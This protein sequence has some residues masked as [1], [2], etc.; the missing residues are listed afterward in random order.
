MALVEEKR[1]H[2]QAHPRGLQTAGGDAPGRT[3]W[4]REGPRRR[5]V[6]SANV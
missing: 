5:R 4:T 2:P 6:V 3:W 1:P